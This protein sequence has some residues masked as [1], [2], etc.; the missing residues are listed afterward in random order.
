MGGKKQSLGWRSEREREWGDK[1]EKKEKGSRDN[2]SKKNGKWWKMWELK[3]GRLIFFW[4]P[5]NGWE[6]VLSIHSLTFF[7]PFKTS[8]VG[9]MKFLFCSLYPQ[10]PFD[11]C[12]YH[13]YD[14]HVCIFHSDM[15]YDHYNIK[16]GLIWEFVNHESVSK[17]RKGKKG[18]WERKGRMERGRRNG[19]VWEGKWKYERKS[20]KWNIGKEIKRRKEEIEY[21]R[22]EVWEKREEV[23]MMK[24]WRKRKAIIFSLYCYPHLFFRHLP[25]ILPFSLTHTFFLSFSVYNY[26]PFI[27]F[28]SFVSVISSFLSV[29][30]SLSVLCIKEKWEERERE[31]ERRKG[32]KENWTLGAK[33]K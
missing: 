17:K 8:C 14:I 18:E 9:W 5:K 22:K 1:G 30:P 4:K 27:P 32:K 2:V 33:E 26:L 16:G 21:D 10:E 19:M 20:E 3:N 15:S 31:R 28:L 25:S 29:V 23:E 24:R 13:M 6:V 7:T 11:I 12:I